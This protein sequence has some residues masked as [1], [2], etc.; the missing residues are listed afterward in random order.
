MKKVLIIGYLWP[1]LSGSIR[2]IRL[3]KSLP[4]FGWEPIILTAP[5]RGKPDIRFRIVETPYRDALGFWKRLFGLD[6]DKDIRMQVKERFGATS[7]NSLIDFI[8]ARGGEIIY[9]PDSHKGWKPFAI[10]AGSELL[11]KENID[12]MISIWPVTSHLIASDLKAK[13]RIPWVADF[14]DLWSQNHNYSYGPLRKLLDTRLEQKTMARVDALVTISEPLAEKLRTLHKE[15]AVYAIT[16]GFD[17]EEVNSPP[18][19]LTDKFTI[20]YT[21]TI[22]TG[23]QDTSKLLIALADLISDGIMNP[24]EIEVRF[25]GHKHGW[26]DK[27]IEQYG[28]SRIVKQ[29]GMVSREIVLEKQRESQ[30]LFL[31]KWNDPQEKGIYLGK[32]LEYLGARRPILATGGYDDVITELLNETGA[33]IDAPTM[34]D[35]KNVLKELYQEYKLTGEVAYKGRESEINKYSNRETARK[36]AEIL[37][38]LVSREYTSEAA[39]ES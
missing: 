14:P 18:A 2:I 38:H 16:H 37:D 29:Y 13:Y 9:Y 17:L 23:Q 36:F 27:E 31:L 7:K 39:A 21:G 20:T 5:L 32:T 12:A 4:E 22:Y 6:L 19:K 33:G 30:L 25:Y 28:L 10:K 1:Y 24:N 3:A 11:Q 26:L 34:E 8:L 15:K 35:I